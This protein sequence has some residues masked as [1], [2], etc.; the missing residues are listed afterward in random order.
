MMFCSTFKAKSELTCNIFELLWQL[1]RVSRFAFINSAVLSKFSFHDLGIQS[2]LSRNFSSCN[3]ASLCALSISQF[4]GLTVISNLC[5]IIF[6]YF[7]QGK[8]IY[9][10]TYVSTK[11]I[12]FIF[13]F[14]VGLSFDERTIHVNY[15]ILSCSTEKDINKPRDFFSS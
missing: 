8:Y 3:I 14:L 9:L 15:S 6:Q 4:N 1:I 10:T 11:H 13:I 12:L 5:L 7:T 2:C